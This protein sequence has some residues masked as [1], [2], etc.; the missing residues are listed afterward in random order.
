MS[1]KLPS[2]YTGLSPFL[3]LYGHQPALFPSEDKQLRVPSAFALV[4]RGQCT[5]NWAHPALL[6]NEALFKKVTDHH[7]TPA[8]SYQLG[9]RVWLSTWDRPSH[10]VYIKYAPHFVGLFPISKD[11]NPVAVTLKLPRTMIIHLTLHVS[12]VKLVNEIALV[13]SLKTPL[14]M[15][16]LCRY[17]IFSPL[18]SIFG[19]VCLI[20]L[21]S[22][23]PISA[24]I[25]RLLTS[26]FFS[27]AF[28]SVVWASVTSHS[29]MCRGWTCYLLQ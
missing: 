27:S 3:C 24:S 21:P 12:Q 28:E 14:W 29:C 13:H 8:P 18:P 20:G 16:V 10:L 23:V 4:H 1:V 17:Y 6:K 26:S 9:Q 19:F 15:A 5:W 7:R 2:T 11:I 25:K 22:C